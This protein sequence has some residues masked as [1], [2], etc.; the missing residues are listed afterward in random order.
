MQS[1]SKKPIGELIKWTISQKLADPKK[2]PNLAKLMFDNLAF[3]TSK[4]SNEA[5]INAAE[6]ELEFYQKASQFL[7]KEFNASV[8]VYA[9]GQENVYDPKNKAA[10]ALPLRP[11]IYI[12]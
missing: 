7:E 10:T 2:A 12:E 9:E 11:G 4:Y 8:E 6:R 3:Y 5:I 1:K